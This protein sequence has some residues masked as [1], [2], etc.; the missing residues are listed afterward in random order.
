LGRVAM[1]RVATKQDSSGVG[2][3]HYVIHQSIKTGDCFY[4]AKCDWLCIRNC[5]C[6]NL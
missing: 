1:C 5:K 2:V 4:C 3:S 6:N